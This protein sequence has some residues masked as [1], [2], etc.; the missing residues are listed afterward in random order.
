MNYTYSP[1][2]AAALAAHNVACQRLNV[3]S[4]AYRAMKITDAEF[5][6]EHNAWKEATAIYDAAYS[7]EEAREE[8]ATK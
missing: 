7:A 8:S 1:E 6:A 3:A 2:Y 4:A 5:I